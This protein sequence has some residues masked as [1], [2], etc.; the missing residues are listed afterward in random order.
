MALKEADT[1]PTTGANMAN[2]G[3]AIDLGT[4]I[5]PRTASI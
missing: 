2:T 1:G 4:E 5:S 3:E